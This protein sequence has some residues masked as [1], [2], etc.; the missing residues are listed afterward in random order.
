MY[1]LISMK[2]CA[3]G[4]I[5]KA[6]RHLPFNR[7]LKRRFLFAKKNYFRTRLYFKPHVEEHRRTPFSSI[8]SCIAQGMHLRSLTLNEILIVYF[9]PFSLRDNKRKMLRVLLVQCETFVLCKRYSDV[10]DIRVAT[11]QNWLT[12]HVLP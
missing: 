2:C 8:A 7:G 12:C 6:E 10:C 11:E 3:L 4:L 1:L 5:C 9:V